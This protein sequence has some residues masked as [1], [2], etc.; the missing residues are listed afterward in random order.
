MAD[1]SKIN[2][3]INGSSEYNI[4]DTTARD[5]LTDRPTS[6]VGT[7]SEWNALPVATQAKY[8]L[9][10]LKGE[11]VYKNNGTGLELIADV[12]GE[13]VYASNVVYDNSSSGLSATEVQSAID[14]LKTNFQAG[15]DDIYDAVVAKGSTPASHS[16]SDVVTGIG[17][18]PTGITPTGTKSIASNGTYDVTEYANADVNVPGPVLIGTYTGDKTIDVASYKRSTDTVNNFI[19][20]F[21]STSGSINKY[22]SDLSDTVYGTVTSSGY[23]S[24]SL[25]GTSLTVKARLYLRVYQNWQGSG[26]LNATGTCNIQYRVY[27]I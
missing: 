26:A 5:G 24:K 12:G 16:L 7:R 20:E 3:N 13:D 27:H 18:I 1:I 9:I 15:V 2:I 19:I 11:G 4:K 14:E 21:V 8:S 23:F 25:S 17:N 10:N 22:A 6:F